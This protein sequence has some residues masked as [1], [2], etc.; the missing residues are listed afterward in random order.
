LPLRLDVFPSWQRVAAERTHGGAHVGRRHEERGGEPVRL[1]LGGR[2]LLAGAAEDGRLLAHVVLAEQRGGDLLHLDERAVQVPVP[3]L[4]GERERETPLLA[5]DHQGLVDED[6]LVLDERRTEHVGHADEVGQVDVDEVELEVALEDVLDVDGRAH[7][8]ALV[9]GVLVQQLVRRAL[10]LLLVQEG[11]LQ[12]WNH[13]PPF[14]LVSSH[15]RNSAPVTFCSR[16]RRNITGMSGSALISFSTSSGTRPASCISSSRLSSSTSASARSV[17]S[18]GGLGS[19]QFS[20]RDR[21][22]GETPTLAAVSR[23]LRSRAMRTRLRRCP[24]FSRLAMS[25]AHPGRH[26]REMLCSRYCTLHTG[27][28]RDHQAVDDLPVPLRASGPRF[29]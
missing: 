8:L 29:S 5:L 6:A 11:D 19:R 28:K 22:V 10:D 13:L 12:L 9:L 27:R 7:G 26:A 15:S 20:T 18:V 25:L 21:Y 24:S 1:P 2:L 23:R 16:A 17:F 3:A 4:V 14:F